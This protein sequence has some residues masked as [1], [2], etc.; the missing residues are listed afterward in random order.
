MTPQGGR[1]FMPCLHDASHARWLKHTPTTGV[2]RVLPQVF[3][4]MKSGLLTLLN[5]GPSSEYFELLLQA[6][7]NAKNVWSFCFPTAKQQW[8]FFGGEWG[9]RMMWSKTLRVHHLWLDLSGL[10]F[11]EFWGVM[12]ICQ[13]WVLFSMISG[14]LDVFGSSATSNFSTTGTGQWAPCDRSNPEALPSLKLTEPMEIPIF[15]SKYHQNGGFSSQP[16]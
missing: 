16:C 15:P 13:T 9:S 10:E 3:S 11:Y 14:L 6:A 8:F 2:C 4:N 7:G 5:N 12:S 1:G